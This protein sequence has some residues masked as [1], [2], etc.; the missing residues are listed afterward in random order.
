MCVCVCVR[1]RACV[2]VCVCVR[3]LVCV[4]M[5]ASVNTSVECVCTCA[6]MHVRD[7]RRVQDMGACICICVI[8]A[9]IRTYVCYWWLHKS[10]LAHLHPPSVATHNAP[11][12]TPPQRVETQT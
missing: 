1:V 7:L 12:V 11:G 5:H 9:Y 4:C 3:V 2:S 8:L 10:L 6:C